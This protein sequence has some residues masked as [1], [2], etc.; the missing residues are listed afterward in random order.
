M[1]NPSNLDPFYQPAIFNIH[2]EPIMSTYER[3]GICVQ[4]NGGLINYLR[5]YSD[6][7][8]ES[9]GKERA[10]RKAQCGKPNQLQM[11]FK[12][13]RNSPSNGCIKEKRH[14]KA[15]LTISKIGRREK[16]N[17]WSLLKIREPIKAG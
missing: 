4:I 16:R 1:S 8:V 11:C 5:C 3:L 6:N 7:R 15:S 9:R 12:K 17:C 14:R 13:C 2:S 10:F